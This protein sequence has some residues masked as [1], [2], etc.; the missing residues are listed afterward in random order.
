MAT[1]GMVAPEICYGC[2][3]VARFPIKYVWFLN[4][5]LTFILPWI[6]YELYN[7]FFKY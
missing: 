7:K 4:D 5:E 2:V 3:P 6:L 1:L